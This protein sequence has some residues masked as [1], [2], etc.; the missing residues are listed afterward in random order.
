MTYQRPFY[1][2]QT[3]QGA[4]NGMIRHNLEK[5]LTT[6]PGTSMPFTDMYPLRETLLMYADQTQ[7]QP[8]TYFHL[9]D[10]T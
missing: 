6:L 2:I 9:L 8:L 4:Y 1:F 10:N 3:K 7:R 5:A